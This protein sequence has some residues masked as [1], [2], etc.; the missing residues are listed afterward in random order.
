[1]N[2]DSK[3]IQIN[4]KSIICQCGGNVDFILSL[5]EACNLCNIYGITSNLKHLQITLNI[6]VIKL[7]GKYLNVLLHF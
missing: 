7:L 4:E 6:S 3:R 5:Q 1:M 2:K